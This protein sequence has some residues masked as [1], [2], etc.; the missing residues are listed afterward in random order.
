MKFGRLLEEVANPKYFHYYI[1]Y[2]TLKK[3]VKVYTDKN[4][5]IPTLQRITTGTNDFNGAVA[6]ESLFM[7]LLDKELHKVNHFAQSKVDEMLGSLRD[8]NNKITAPR[9]TKEELSE[10]EKIADAIGE[11]II[12]L[13]AYIQQ[14]LTGFRKIIKKHDKA[15]GACVAPYF[16]SRLSK[17]PFCN[18]RT[19]QLLIALSA[20]YAHIRDARNALPAN[21]GV[22]VPPESF[23]RKTTKYWVNLEHIM[24]LKVTVVKHLPILIFGASESEQEAL[25]SPYFEDQR[26]EL[27]DAQLIT[28]VYFD[29]DDAQLYHTRMDRE[30]GAELIRFRWYGENDGSDD[31]EVYIER[32]THHESWVLEDSVKERFKIKQMHV[33]PFM[34]GTYSLDKKVEKMKEKNKKK[35]KEFDTML[36]LSKDIQQSLLSKKLKPMVRTTYLRAAF[37]LSSSN[38]VRISLDTR[39]SLVNENVE[40]TSDLWCRTMSDPVSMN[41][42]VR[43]PYGI[44]EVK[45]GIENP[46]S[47]VQELIDDPNVIQMSKFSKFQH[48]IAFL[49][50][51][52]VRIFPHWFDEFIDVYQQQQLKLEELK[53]VK[54]NRRLTEDES[55]SSGPVKV[56]I[57][58]PYAPPDDV[59]SLTA[60]SPMTKRKVNPSDDSKQPLLG[61]ASSSETRIRVPTVVSSS[62]RKSSS[63][64][65]PVGL[66]HR[67]KMCLGLA[68]KPAH[69]ITVGG[70]EK[71]IK[72]AVVKVEPKTYF[73][74]ERTLLHW[75]QTSVLLCTI[76]LTLLNFG[77]KHAKICG[78][79]LAPVAMFFIIYSFLVYFKRTRAIKQREVIRYDERM[80]PSMLVFFLLLAMCTIVIFNLVANPL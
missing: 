2:K 5:T 12:F 57:V 7:D 36:K 66:T 67:I 43:F 16:L 32:K 56:D 14:N 75:L 53:K 73:A 78:V 33:L 76:S 49:H 18:L 52:M 79:I 48:G 63:K 6:V 11:D 24:K 19:D 35:E 17:E 21:K 13:D 23:S 3:A 74:N 70:V 58:K 34:E 54:E 22:W 25:L 9:V 45:L 65:R 59:P 1:S 39:L 20:V 69:T 28:S 47:W 61:G 29:N 38:D 50:G 77:H 80:G 60:P 30:E 4:V 42:V 68:S 51:H 40:R 64:K 71:P 15:I 41:E 26:K 72:K 8:L 62:T 44:L 31:K 55:A 37:Q 10:Y 46:P 27:A